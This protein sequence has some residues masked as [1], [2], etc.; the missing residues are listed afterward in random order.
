MA[1][2]WP[3][4][5]AHIICIVSYPIRKKSRFWLFHMWSDKEMYH[6]L[7]SWETLRDNRERAWSQARDIPDCYLEH[8]CSFRRMKL[9]RFN[10]F[11]L[12]P[13]SQ[14]FIITFQVNQIFLMLETKN[15]IGSDGIEKFQ[16]QLRGGFSRLML[17]PFRKLNI[18]N[19]ILKAVLT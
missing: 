18:F 4:G 17:V 13:L 2:F 6:A 16:T 9:I 5:A 11:P 19:V 10:F 14:Y 12:L 7:F 1:A 8:E 3:I 15:S